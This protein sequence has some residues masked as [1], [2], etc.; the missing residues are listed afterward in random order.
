M[1]ST[2]PTF[3]EINQ[4]KGSIYDLD[5]SIQSLKAHYDQII[6]ALDPDQE[7][8]AKA[9]LKKDD[10]NIEK[11]F[12]DLRYTIQVCKQCPHLEKIADTLQ[13]CLG[14]AYGKYQMGR[15]EYEK[16]KERRTKRQYEIIGGEVP[17]SH[18]EV[19]NGS[20]FANYLLEIDKN[21]QSTHALS[22]V[23][24][25]HTEVQNIEGG[26]STLARLFEE[27]EELIKQQ[28]EPI[29]AIERNGEQAVEQL[30]A[31][32]SEETK[33]TKYARSRLRKKWW[34]LLIAST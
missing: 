27:V 21:Y 22:N 2:A 7:R 3:A 32:I 4:I 31:G 29:K 1:Q 26:V 12:E 15:R 24:N 14:T 5:N 20:I 16:R 23:T 9:E 34:A 13:R 33:A 17:T 30:K 19:E 28:E 10:S 18:P 25:R 6:D 11:E 8:K